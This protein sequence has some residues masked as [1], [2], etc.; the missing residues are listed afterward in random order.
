MMLRTKRD[1]D[2]KTL[3]YDV[4]DEQA[5]SRTASFVANPYKMKIPA[6]RTGKGIQSC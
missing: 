5:C 2:K 6:S 4:H 1:K 3:K